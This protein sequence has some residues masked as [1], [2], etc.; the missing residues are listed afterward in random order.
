MDITAEV[1]TIGSE[2][3]KGSVLNTNAQYLAQRFVDLGIQVENQT[4]C[5]DQIPAIKAALHGALSRSQIVIATGGLGPTPDDVT[6]D[7]VAEF[8][9]VPLVFSPKQYQSI[10][11]YYRR[12]RKKVPELVKKEAMYPCGSIPLVNR[13]GIALGFYMTCG[14]KLLVVLPGVPKEME[15]MFRGLVEPLIVSLYPFIRKK[16][17][18][19]A[20]TVGLSEL[21]VMTRLKKDF[22]D[23]PFQFGIYPMP[24]EVTL[25]IY[26]ENDA[27]IQKLK[28]KIQ[29]RLGRDVYAFSENSLAEIVGKLLV[30]SKK[31][32]AVA[33]SCTGGGLSAEITKNPGASDYYLGGITA[34]HNDIKKLIGISGRQLNRYGA[35]SRQVA[36]AMARQIQKM[37]KS[38]YGI[39]ITGIAGPGGGSLRKPVGL[40]YIAVG[41]RKKMLSK[42]YLFWGERHQVQEKAVQKALEMLRSLLIRYA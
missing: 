41:G 12:L 7:A 1:L 2:L 32:L 36:S 10:S 5:D 37:F 40:V 38:D 9:N 42:K 23:V 20:K 39:A 35:V 27:V 30:K 16:S 22:F 21:A 3:L 8:F 33:E 11:R 29:K 26:A 25:R 24:G 31:T 17:F 19:V 15:A 13:F 14:G 28:A 18:L 4:S 6:R 34:Y